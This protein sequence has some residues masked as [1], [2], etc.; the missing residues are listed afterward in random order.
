MRRFKCVRLA[1]FQG[2][3]GDVGQGVRIVYFSFLISSPPE[4]GISAFFC[5]FPITEFSVVLLSAVMPS[6]V[7]IKDLH[8]HALP[9]SLTPDDP[10]T[11]VTGSFMDA[12]MIC[13]QIL[14]GQMCIALAW[15]CGLINPERLGVLNVLAG[16][17]PY[18]S[19]GL[20]PTSAFQHM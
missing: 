16:D 9:I 6:H 7:K 18:L 2:D 19:V 15:L 5:I 3:C 10:I 17:V 13:E 11:S 8:W 4:W 14:Y 1:K 20:Y 12:R